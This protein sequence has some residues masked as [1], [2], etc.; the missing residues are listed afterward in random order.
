MKRK[1][2]HEDM[3]CIDWTQRLSDQVLIPVINNRINEIK[4]LRQKMSPS[5]SD[6]SPISTIRDPCILPNKNIL[7]TTS[8]PNIV[9]LHQIDSSQDTLPNKRGVI[10]LTYHPT[11][12]LKK[13]G[14]RNQG[15]QEGATL[16][17]PISLDWNNW[18]HKNPY[19]LDFLD[20]HFPPCPMHPLL[21]VL[22]APIK[23]ATPRQL[24]LC[25]FLFWEF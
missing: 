13:C 18:G 6:N 11:N 1:R 19:L 3:L 22:V 20:T 23:I 7:P 2:N 17:L 9:V 25:M 4:N 8:S 15:S 16:V 14:T 24:F 10:F 21:I 12:H 5:R